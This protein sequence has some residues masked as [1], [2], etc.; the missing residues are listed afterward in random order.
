[1]RF[2]FIA[3]AFSA[4]LLF[5]QSESIE[6]HGKLID[7]ID[8]SPIENASIRIVEINRYDVTDKFGDFEFN[9]EKKSDFSIEATRIGYVPFSRKYKT[10]ELK[11][12][13]LIIH[14]NRITYIT[15][16]IVVTGIH[17][18]FYDNHSIHSKLQGKNLERNIGQTLALSLKN[19]VGI[20]FRS[21]GLAPSR[22]VF[23]GL[24]NDRLHLSEDGF[25][26]VDLSSTSPDHAVSIE[27]FTI[28]RIEVLRGP[29]VLM[30]NTVA[31]GGVINAVKNEIPEHIPNKIN[32]FMGSFYETT[33]NGILGSAIL[34]V[35]INSF[36]F[37]GEF[38]KR[39]TN[40]Q[41]TPLGE[42]K[43]TE[44]ANLNYSFSTAYISNDFYAGLL[45]KE[46]SSEYGIPGG[47][48]GG[49]LNGVDISLMKRNIHSVLRYSLN[50]K[51]TDAVQLKLGRNYYRHTEYEDKQLI[52]AEFLLFSYF[53][54][55]TLK[56]SNLMGIN[57][58]STGFL[59]N[60]FDKKVGGYVFTPATE[61]Y[62]IAHYSH[63]A[64]SINDFSF[65]FS[66]RL[67]S[68][69]F[70]PNK[71]F[72]TRQGFNQN[73][74]FI[75]YSIA[76]SV[77]YHFDSNNLVGIN[78]S[79]SSRTPSIE[80]LYSEGPHLAA[81]S[82]DI[83][84]PN[85]KSEHGFGNELFASVKPFNNDASLNI[86]LFY[87]NIWSYIA[88]RN[89]G[90]INY[91]KLVPIYQASQVNA[92]IYG[93]E[94][95]LQGKINS[96]LSYNSSISFTKGIRKNTENNINGNL[97][98]IP[99]IKNINQIILNFDRLTF[100]LV[101]EI[102]GDQQKVDEFETTTSGYIIFNLFAQYSVELNKYFPF[103]GSIAN[104]TINID[105]ITNK[106]HYNH[107]SR[108][109]SISPESGR[110]IRV[111]VRFYY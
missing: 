102:V 35:P 79:K 106:L 42:L 32:L 76:G 104:F 78:F 51:V 52:G 108:I 45:I 2:L 91:A 13:C 73:K 86:N 111:S 5:S 7:A 66:Y 80:E 70:F 22:P 54:D 21:M 28:Q 48:V 69:Y 87:N 36:A 14:L 90:R 34:T 55:F 67:F 8:H 10:S 64:K 38:T 33:N 96:F 9:V 63:L 19:E 47:F 1:M 6:I 11:D 109:K 40:N 30:M 50:N 25:G 82:Y 62:N 56:L 60:Y 43:N 24:S 29:R 68:D 16:P 71:N 97:P 94:I 44:I 26:T 46:Y 58:F 15:A 3:V 95:S 65:E 84:N 4:Y 88:N 89:T 110:N 57:E 59:L 83:G 49:H 37:R 92:S 20:S 99:P 101:N 107:L 81:Y 100:G 77:I 85:L 75:N 61:H 53:A 18:D 72:T 103:A 17:T 23:R 39:K 98:S 93:Y 31:F 105:N 74:S 41:H 12:L 27:P